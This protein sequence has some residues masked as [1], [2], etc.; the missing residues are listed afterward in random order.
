MGEKWLR[1]S[2]TRKARP[3]IRTTK[4]RYQIP[5]FPMPGG[6]SPAG[7]SA[8]CHFILIIPTPPEIKRGPTGRLGMVSCKSVCSGSLPDA[9]RPPGGGQLAG[10]QLVVQHAAGRYVLRMQQDGIVSRRVVAPYA[11]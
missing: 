2:G 9:D 5:C 1:Y 10:L 7:L 3:P 8:G 11:M 6:L 4:R